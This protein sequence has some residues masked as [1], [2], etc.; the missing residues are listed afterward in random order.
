[1]EIDINK[2]VLKTPFTKEQQKII[3]ERFR[4]FRTK[5]QLENSARTFGSQLKL[6]G[7]SVNKIIEELLKAIDEPDE[8]KVTSKK[9]EVKADG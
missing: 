5:H 2:L 4:R 3:A 6:N 1:M 8:P 7:L 9:A